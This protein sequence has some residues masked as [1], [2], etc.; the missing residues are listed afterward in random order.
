MRIK[1]TP[2]DF[3]VEEL[4]AYAPSG[5]GEHLFVRFEKRDM[6]TRDA[7]RR[8]A[9]AL[10]VDPREAGVAGQKDKRAV[11][12]QTA[13]F[14][15][16]SPETALG[17]ELPGIRVLEA[18]PHGHKLRPG[19]LAGNRFRVGVRGLSA[20]QLQELE[21]RVRAASI[22]GIPNAFGAQ[23][24][25][26]R[27]DNAGRARRFLRGEERPPR[28][29]RERA[30]LFSALQARV[31]NRVLE[32]RVGDG[33]WARALAGD[34]LKKHD[35]GGLFVCTDVQTDDA[36]ARRGE[37]SATGPLP[38]V[39]ARRPEGEPRALEER[40]EREELEGVDLGRWRALGEGTRRS[41]RI[42]ASA[43]EAS[44]GGEAEPGVCTLRF[45]LPKGAFATTLLEHLFPDLEG[46]SDELSQASNVEEGD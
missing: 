30:L 34:L 2:E 8:I 28:D 26:A 10:G 7:V 42:F 32:A 1:E 14:F 39:K 44:P 25:G 35:T 24:F 9:E 22:Q 36:R 29:R 43:L 46:A 38:G 15:R 11:T 33:T 20:I 23:R 19:H 3:V 40:I 31:F 37:V 27:G 45:V 12:T 4:P 6:T 16:A 13:S 17:L 5:E 41:L 21:A 18:R